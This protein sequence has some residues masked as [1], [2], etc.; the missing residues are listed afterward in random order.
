MFSQKRHQR[1]SQLPSIA[2]LK[3]RR[4][5]WHHFPLTCYYRRTLKMILIL[6]TFLGFICVFWERCTVWKITLKQTI[7]EIKQYVRR[8]N[9]SSRHLLLP[10]FNTQTVMIKQVRMMRVSRGAL[11]PSDTLIDTLRVALLS[12][13]A[14]G[15][16]RPRLWLLSAHSP[17]CQDWFPAAA[18]ARKHKHL[19]ANTH[20]P[21][22][23]H[24]H[25]QHRAFV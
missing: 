18:H 10:V 21:A 25:T 4:L 8:C 24:T 15:T 17:R 16:C 9:L 2:S 12:L 14:A 7:L 11:A 1:I 13:S 5:Y 3:K 6:F 22:H 20:T 23:Q 19:L